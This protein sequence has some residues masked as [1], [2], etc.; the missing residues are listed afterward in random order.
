MDL[1]KTKAKEK[2]KR[3]GDNA[4]SKRKDRDLKSYACADYRR[5]CASLSTEALRDSES[6]GQKTLRA[7]K[8][9]MS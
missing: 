8:L 1:R 6:L 3:T 7:V 5:G 4:Q 2:P 9:K